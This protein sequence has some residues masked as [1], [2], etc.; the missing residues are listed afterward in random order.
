MASKKKVV[1]ETHASDDVSTETVNEQETVHETEF[2]FDVPL[3]SRA[4]GRK[5]GPKAANEALIDFLVKMPV[6]ASKLIPLEGRP[7]KVVR[8]AIGTALRRT[9]EVS[10]ITETGKNRISRTRRYHVAMEGEDN[11]RVWHVAL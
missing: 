2:D 5:G 4:F 9:S 10:F 6:G 3:P 11:C 7:L 8:T 1:T